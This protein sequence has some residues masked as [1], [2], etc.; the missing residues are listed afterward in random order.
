MKEGVWVSK[1]QPAPGRRRRRGQQ[2]PPRLPIRKV[3]IVKWPFPRRSQCVESRRAAGATQHH[4]PPP[5]ASAPASSPG[6][7]RPGSLLPRRPEQG[8]KRREARAAPG[9]WGAAERG[10]GPGQD[11]L[12]SGPQASA[13]Q[14]GQQNSAVRSQ[15]ALLPEGLRQGQCQPPADPAPRLPAEPQAAPRA[16]PEGSGL[17]SPRVRAGGWALAGRAAGG[18]LGG[19]EGCSHGAGGAQG[20]HGCWRG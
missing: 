12:S 6:K 20:A 9:G 2:R 13:G 18:P 10:I 1:A 16:P 14:P 4:L 5:P 3:F 11:M 8:G 17:E 19:K 15:R 7:G